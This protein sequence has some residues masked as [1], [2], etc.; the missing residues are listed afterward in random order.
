[1][2]ANAFFPIVA[3]LGCCA[4]SAK[5]QPLEA[6]PAVHISASESGSW[7]VLYRVAA[8]TT[9]LVFPR[10][11]D[12][13]RVSTWNVEDGFEIVT[14]DD[15]EVVRRSD[16]AS[17]QTVTAAIPAV[18]RELPSDYAPF[19]PFGDGGML[20]YSG[21]LFACPDAC[22]GDERWLMEL[23][24][25]G[26]EIL[27]DGE[28]RRDSAFWTDGGEGRNIYLG[29]AEPVAT[30]EFLAVLDMKLPENVRNRLL[31]QL[32]LYMRY[33]R[34][35][36]GTLAE[37]PVLFASYDTNQAGGRWG[38]Q[39]GVLPGQVFVHFYGHKWEEEMAKPNFGPDLAWH[40]AHEAAHF[41]QRMRYGRGK[42][43]T[44]IHE[45]GAEAMAALALLA[46]DPSSAP[47]LRERSQQAEAQC[48]EELGDRSLYETLAAGKSEA[49]YSCGL[50]LNLALHAELRRRRPERDGLY[51]VWR[52][53][54]QNADSKGG[55]A[56]FLAAVEA[57][58]GKTLSDKVAKAARGSFANL[59]L[60]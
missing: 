47:Y 16:G 27:V 3:L 60:P 29:S 49:A 17:F 30:G 8:P 59:R 51:D 43:D 10:S 55:E 18:Y 26:R 31:T 5:E 50:V 20:F 7:S 13:S 35:R 32:P 44:W 11:P 33:F 34:E 48:A 40:F 42:E 53:Y 15:G 36:L 2:T 6:I 25:T 4:A 24:A 46:T 54:I 37:K 41:F 28:H 14:T 22:N 12:A 52:R 19:S 56:A 45:G 9:R 39:G 58:G 21:R 23:E 1:M 57:S 38:R